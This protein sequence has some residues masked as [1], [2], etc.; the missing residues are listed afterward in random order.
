MEFNFDNDKPIYL[1]VIRQMKILVASNTLK[2][3]EKIQS[4][5]DLATDNRVNPNTIQ[6]A[7]VEL[8]KEKIICSKSTSGNYVTDDIKIIKK[9]KEELI[10]DFLNEFI[11]N[12]SD[13]GISK[14]EIINYINSYERKNYGKEK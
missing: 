13:V 1:Q 12:M 10:E 6:K 7:L 3:G 8:E 5:R 2:Q 11:I 9:I 14:E 4:V